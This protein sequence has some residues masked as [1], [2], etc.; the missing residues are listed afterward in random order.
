MILVG[1]L[2]AGIALHILNNLLA[3]GFAVA[4]NQLDST[5]TVS[6]ASWWQLPVTVVQNGVFLVLAL[7]S[8]AGW[9]CATTHRPGAGAGGPSLTPRSRDRH[10][11]P[12]GGPAGVRVTLSLG[13]PGSHSRSRGRSHGVWGNWQPDWFWSS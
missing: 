4:L 1:G 7:W 10:T 8:R 2:E 12:I 5:L 9:G 11:D 3:F 13:P 6:S